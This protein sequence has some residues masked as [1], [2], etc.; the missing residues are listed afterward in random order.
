M[1]R[2]Q[3]R[4]DAWTESALLTQAYSPWRKSAISKK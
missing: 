2:K 4:I 1:V 3:L